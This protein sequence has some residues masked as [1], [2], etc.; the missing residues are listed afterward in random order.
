MENSFH[1]LSAR[2]SVDSGAHSA[3]DSLHRIDWPI[4]GLLSHLQ[5]IVDVG[6]L[7]NL[8]LFIRFISEGSLGF[9][10]E[11]LQSLLGKV[12]SQAPDKFVAAAA[13]NPVCN[14]ALMVGTTDIPDWVYV[15]EAYGSE[16]K[17][18]FTDAP[19]AEHLTLFQKPSP[20]AHVS[21]VY[22]VFR[23]L[24]FHIHDIMIVLWILKL[25]LEVY[26]NRRENLQK[27]LK[28]NK[29]QDN[30]SPNID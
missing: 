10:E 26:W 2:S 13:R 22:A 27:L 14:L 17:N 23:L 19:S 11:A 18:S 1:F 3:T 25:L 28:P 16:G 29:S 12:G 7:F 4:D 30:S 9:G 6:E 24:T 20:V 15:E 21:K 8:S 5:K